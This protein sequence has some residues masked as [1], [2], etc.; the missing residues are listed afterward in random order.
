M[1][2]AKETASTDSISDGSAPYAGWSSTEG[3]DGGVRRKRRKKRRGDE[4]QASLNINSLMD[5][6]TILLVYLLK[7]FATSP[8]EVKDP[9][10]SLPISNSME[11]VEEATVVM[12]TGPQKTVPNPADPKGSIVVENVPAI[13]VDGTPVLTLDPASYRVPAEYKD[14]ASGGFVINALR[15]KLSEAREMQSAAAAIS[16]SAGF[17]GKVVIIADKNTPFRVLT[18]VLV[19]CGSAGFGEFRFAIVKEKG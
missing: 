12:V 7:S 2:Q 4:Q 11:N 3:D 17:T 8:I 18:D 5:I 10:I 9:A 6:V 1:T 13:V 15:A 14:Q 19:T 16:D